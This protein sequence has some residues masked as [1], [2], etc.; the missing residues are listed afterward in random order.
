MEIVLLAC[1]NGMKIFS[2]NLLLAMYGFLF[3]SPLLQIYLHERK[4][5]RLMISQIL[6]LVNQS[7]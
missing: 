1:T 5:Y 7:S 3:F 6:S 4:K 2:Q